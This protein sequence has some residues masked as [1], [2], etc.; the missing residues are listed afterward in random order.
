MKNWNVLTECKSEINANNIKIFIYRMKI[1]DLN[2][3]HIENFFLVREL[4]N[5]NN[6]KF[7]V[8]YEEYIASFEEIKIWRKTKYEEAY[9][10]EIDL[11][12]PKEKKLLERLL[13]KDIT[14]N[15]NIKEYKA[16]R[17]S[18]YFKNEVYDLHGIIIY[19]YID[20]D[21]NIEE[22]GSIIVGFDVKH[23]F[24]YKDNLIKN[25][26]INTGDKVKD[27]VN[28]ITYTFLKWADFTIGEYNKYLGGSIVDYYKNKNKENI[29]SNVSKETKAVIVIN[30]KNQE[31]PYSPNL[32][33]KV[34]TFNMI[35]LKAK[36]SVDLAIKLPVHD[37][38]ELLKNS[39][40]NITKE[41]KYLKLIKNNIVID[42]LGYQVIKI[43]APNLIFGNNKFMRFNNFNGLN[44]YG[45]Y[46]SKTI[47]VT[48]FIDPEIL[49]SEEEKKKVKNFANKIEDYSKKLG[50]ILER[51][52]KNN[53]VKFKSIN[54]S[55]ENVFAYDLKKILEKYNQKETVIF[56]LKDGN[57]R[58]YYEIIKNTFGY[59]GSIASQCISY[60]TVLKTR[61]A[62]DKGNFE[63]YIYFNI[64]LGIYGKSGVQPW[65]LE[66]PLNSDCLIGLDITRENNVNK[67]GI[68]QV[69][70]KDGRVLRSK[71]ISAFVKGEKIPKDIMKIT[72]LEAI[73]AFEKAYN[74]KPKHITFHRDG[75]NREELE[76]I[77]ELLNELKIE[78]DYIEITKDTNRRMATMKDERQENKSK[79]DMK[80]DTVLGQSYVKGNIGFICTTKS[81]SFG[82]AKP[83][84][85]KKVYGSLDMKNILSDVYKLTFM[86]VGALNKIRL[87]ITTY[88]ADLSAT[89]GLRNLM[90]TE[91]ETNLLHF[92]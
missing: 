8:F 23:S 32:L 36:P 69:V 74:K 17:N 73:T 43:N 70:G 51:Q 38:M 41:T 83:L 56:I 1:R 21:I 46:D 4:M 13:L 31:F 33:K 91:E 82:M 2:E 60:S 86:H 85:I 63:K 18:I 49:T 65:I 54:I 19:R 50:V 16:I 84:R 14:E 5:L 11:N 72:V 10:K 58:K 28:N 15:V 57:I 67:T 89:F 44:N 35:P 7:I 53:E 25:K 64:L 81:F 55:N 77:K 80:W 24:E 71:I 37:K 27:H 61:A 76:D 68:I 48:Y 29:I 90:P 79:E 40:F 66:E 9:N 47:K 20:F 78:F 88:Y 59:M 87:P 45:V 92:I 42:K 34:C 75:I 30:N 62:E 52:R 22:D 12:S 26:D 39:F 6:N 3:K